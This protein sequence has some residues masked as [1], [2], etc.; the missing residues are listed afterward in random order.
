MKTV[1]F[2]LETTSLYTHDHT[3][4]NWEVLDCSGVSAAN[5]YVFSSLPILKSMRLIDSEVKSVEKF[6]CLSFFDWLLKYT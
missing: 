6:V 4:S 3:F 5:T 2:K 1:Q